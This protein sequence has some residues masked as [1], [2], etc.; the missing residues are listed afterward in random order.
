MHLLSLSIRN[1]LVLLRLHA[2]DYLKCNYRPKDA[3]RAMK[4]RVVGN[5]N[6][7]EVMLALTVSV[8][9]PRILIRC[10]WVI[11]SKVLL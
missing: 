9:S 7:K 5:K 1:Q 6:F 4:K 8:E 10:A 11:I 3:V 2:T